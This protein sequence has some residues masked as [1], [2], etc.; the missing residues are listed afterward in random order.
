[1]LVGVYVFL[2]TFLHAIP[3]KVGRIIGAGMLAQIVVGFEAV[4][5][6]ITFTK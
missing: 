6:E 2:T 4:R 1:M 3:T 5:A